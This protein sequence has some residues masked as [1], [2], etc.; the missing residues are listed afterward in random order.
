LEGFRSQLQQLFV[1]VRRPTYRSL[2]LHADQHGRTL[3]TSTIGN[4][5]NG[6]P[7]PR[8]DTVETFVRACASY[9]QARKIDLPPRV[10]DLDRWH[11]DYQ[12]MENALAD[13]AARREQIAGQPV[14]ARRRRLA[15]PAQLPPDVSAFTGRTQHLATLDKLLPSDEPASDIYHGTTAVVISAIDGT[16]GVG[17]TALAVHWAHRVRDRFPDGQLYVNLRGFDPSGQ[18]IDPAAA[19]RGWLDALEIPPARIPTDLDAQTALYRSLLIDKRML[20]VLDNARDSAQV[21]PLLPG[22]PGCLVLITSRNQLTSLIAETAAHTLTLDLLTDQE[23]RDL[24]AH[25]LGADRVAAEPDAVTEIITRCARLPLALT[26]VAAHATVRPHTGLRVL[27]DELRNSQHRWRTLTGDDPTTDVRTVFSWSY[28]ALAPEAARLFRLLGLH[29][30]PDITAPAAASLTA[31]PTGQVQPLL[32]ELTHANLLTEHTTGRYVLHDLLRAYARDLAHATDPDQ[33]RR[34]ATH[35]LLDHYLHATHTAA[36]L[37]QPHRDPIIPIPPQPGVTPETPADYEQALT[38]FTA[39]HPVLLAAV[40][41]AVATGFDTHTWQ[42]AWTLT[43]FLNWRGH[44]H[45]QA[46]TGHAAVAAA[47]RL[48][49]PTAQARAHRILAIAYNRLGRVDDAYTHL[50]HALD[51]YTQAG[52][53]AGQAHTHHALGQTREQQGRHTKALHH[54]RQ[55]LDL[56]RATGDQWGQALALNAVGWDYA[57]LG[58]HQ[59]ALTYCQQALTLFQNLNDRPGQAY[60]WDSIGYCHH[61]L[62]QHTQAITCYQHALDLFQ[63]LGDLYNRA[64]A[65]THLGDTH[66]TAGNHQAARDAWQQALVILTDLDHPDAGQVRAKLTSLDPPTDERQ[67]DH[68]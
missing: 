43:D 50:W 24:L 61:H 1:R 7:I 25:R 59:Q 48:G 27:A 39:E 62:G 19:V 56:Y 38:W 14:P 49:D 5:L 4:L 31:V 15:I 47:G 51:L 30:G 64:T 13:Q 68:R 2:E 3:R 60:T 8:W 12:A 37:L 26:L 6:P 55:A 11:A 58:D 66:H 17:K 35:R 67:N 23:A 53:H 20:V 21:R 45:D 16:A 18:A 22:A 10:V 52:D 57:Q 28:Q 42:L 63:D 65:L 33:Q 46:G 41:H 29:P 40:D 54:S 36:R 34:S 32:T 44:W 9:A